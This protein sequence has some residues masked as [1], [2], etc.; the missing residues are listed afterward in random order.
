MGA[1]TWGRSGAAGGGVIITT[2]VASDPYSQ[3]G[4]RAAARAKRTKADERRVA[5]RVVIGGFCV[6]EGQDTTVL[7]SNWSET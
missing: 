6:D 3:A 5:R 4:T 1:S 2:V 7:T